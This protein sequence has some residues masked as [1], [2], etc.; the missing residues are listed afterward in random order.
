MKVVILCGGRGM[1]LM[2]ETEFRPKPLVEI[3][4]R[5]ILW[6]IMKIYDHYG[7]RDFIL[8]AGYKGDMIKEYFLNYRAMND[9]FTIHL[10]KKSE[11]KFHD[12]GAQ[13]EWNITIADTGLESMTGSRLKKIEQY[14]DSDEFMVT[15]G[16]GVTD[17]DIGK[18]VKFHKDSKKIA[19]V[20]GVHPQSRFGELISDGKTVKEFSEKPQVKE[21]YINGGFFVFNKSIFDYLKKDDKCILEREP[22]EKIAKNNQMSIYKHDGFWQCMDTQRDMELLNDVW[23]N[24][25]AAWK[26]W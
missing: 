8:C 24:N 9:D 14:I 5:P 11:M 21:A 23:R 3:G 16:D 25:K 26:V 13:E 12:K 18:L 19:T 10:G 1:R 17:A 4:S 20:L 2:Q 6:H 22:L 15:Y 7:Y